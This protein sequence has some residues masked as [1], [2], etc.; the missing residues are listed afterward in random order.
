MPKAN[1]VLIDK[2]I[3]R[4]LAQLARI[5]L[6]DAEKEK[7]GNNLSGI[8][9]FINK[10]NEVNTDNV[11]PMAGGTELKDVMREDTQEIPHDPIEAAKLVKA[12]PEHEQG[13][14]KVKKVFE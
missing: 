12:A 4:H 1:I 10:L 11:L 3:L 6:T 7:F 5:E 14:V 2:E 13:F 9:D 8:L